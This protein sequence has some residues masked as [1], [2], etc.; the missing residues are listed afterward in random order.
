MP[1]TEQQIISRCNRL[2][3]NNATISQNAGYYW[4]RYT[5]QSAPID[6]RD[7]LG[8]ILL[9]QTGS[10]SRKPVTDIRVKNAYERE[11]VDNRVNMV[12]GKRFGMQLEELKG[13]PLVERLQRFYDRNTLGV[14]AKEIMR[15]SGACGSSAV[16]A[17]QPISDDALD[18]AVMY[19]KPYEYAIQYDGS[20]RPVYA[21]RI[22]T[23]I[24]DAQTAAAAKVEPNATANAG[25]DGHRSGEAVRIV[26]EYWDDEIRVL[27]KGQTH[28]SDTDSA[29]RNALVSS[30]AKKGQKTKG[31]EYAV[32]P[33]SMTANLFGAVPFVEFRGLEGNRPYFYPVVSLIDAYNVLFS[34]AASEFAAFR[35]AY[36]ILK[37]WIVED[38]VDDDGNLVYTKEQML[39]KMRAFF[40]DENGDAKFLTREI[41]T[42]A[43]VQMEK[44]FR[45]NIDR[46]SQN[47]DFTDPE[48]Y[49][50]ATN[51]AIA[52]RLKGMENAANDTADQ[53]E[54][55]MKRLIEV[56]NGLWASG[57]QQIDPW[58]IKFEFP[59]DRP[60]NIGE[61]ATTITTLVQAGVS[62]EDALRVASFVDNPTEWA[63]RAA[64]EKKAMLG[65]MPDFDIETPNGDGGDDDN[66]DEDKDTIE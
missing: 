61:E 23:E 59:Y 31:P 58:S 52:T 20:G 3:H 46:F 12:F 1:A 50:T 38:K 17:Y 8:D 63:E 10:S 5:T 45:H 40:F 35:N 26:C 57:S 42:E 22:Y 41:P 62:L 2:L 39:K 48:V 24:V 64:E 9:T 27:V 11:I 66:G 37:N 18:V 53:F 29:L 6:S 51:M 13:G 60:A 21:I 30:T 55:S 54:L 7:P 47:V 32:A 65:S 16:M 28:Y 25:T 33:E 56:C 49:G 19:L 43:F 14:L 44:L 36:L 4:Q 34:D 15:I